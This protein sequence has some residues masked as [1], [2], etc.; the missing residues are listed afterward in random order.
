MFQRYV[1]QSIFLCYG[2]EIGREGD[3]AHVIEGAWSHIQD[4]KNGAASTVLERIKKYIGICFVAVV[5]SKM[6]MMHAS[7]LTITLGDLNNYQKFLP[8]LVF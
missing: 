2:G 3:L 4:Q 8:L 7:Q 6:K 5:A 1:F